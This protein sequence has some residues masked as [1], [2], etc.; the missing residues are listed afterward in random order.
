VSDS[1][2]PAIPSSLTGTDLVAALNDRFRRVASSVAASSSTA[3]PS[4]P[5][6]PPGAPGASI[7]ASWYTITMNSSMVFVVDLANGFI[8]EVV[9][10]SA[11]ATGTPPTDTTVATIGKPIWTAGTIVKGQPLT[12]YVTQDSTGYWPCPTW[13]TGYGTAVQQQVIRGNPMTRSVFQLRF[14]GTVW[15]PENIRHGDATT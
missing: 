11:T 9:L 3:G 1:T 6:G 5:P 13:A 15:I 14:D 12:L 2:I 7:A 4:G 8:Q 10:T